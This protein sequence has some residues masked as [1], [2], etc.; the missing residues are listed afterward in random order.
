MRLN[1]SVFGVD[2]N[3]AGESARHS[4][5]VDW[6]TVDEQRIDLAETGAHVTKPLEVVRFRGLW[7]QR[8]FCLFD[9]GLKFAWWHAPPF[10][11]L[12]RNRN[13]APLY[14]VIC[15]GNKPILLR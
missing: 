4:A 5:V 3:Q 13:T 8:P 10:L 9:Q 1:L 2:A 12:S 11:Q 14:D 6:G 15:V 7:V